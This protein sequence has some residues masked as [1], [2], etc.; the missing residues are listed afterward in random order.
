MRQKLY[1]SYPRKNC[2]LLS[3]HLQYMTQLTTHFLQKFLFGIA[4]KTASKAIFV[5]DFLREKENIVGVNCHTI[6]N[7]ITAKFISE[8]PSTQNPTTV[9]MLCSLKTYKGVN[10][11][12]QLANMLPKQAFE[13]VLNADKKQ[14]EHFFKGIIIPKNLSVFP[15][16]QNVHPFYNRAKVVLNLSHPDLWVETFGMTALEAMCYKIPVIVPPVGGIAEVVQHEKNGYCISV[17]DL[18]LIKNQ[19]K[20]LYTDENLYK[21]MASA[22]FIRSK[23][24]SIKTLQNSIL[25]QIK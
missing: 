7:A 3:L 6:Y 14:I 18:G 19:I 4:R 24:F 21:K 1:L 5:S 25:K 8:I 17:K 10:E 12:I 16:Q 22:S 2:R 11:F 15:S 20:N 9:L 13:L 23:D